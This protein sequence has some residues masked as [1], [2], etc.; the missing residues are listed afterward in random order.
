M[1][2]D[3]A[4]ICPA[5]GREYLDMQRAAAVSGV[6]LYAVSG[7]RT[8]AEQ[9]VLYAQLGPGI[10]APPGKSLHHAATEFDLARW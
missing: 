2:V 1:R 7:F 5:V 3:A 10:A 8:F 4:T 9:A 6:R